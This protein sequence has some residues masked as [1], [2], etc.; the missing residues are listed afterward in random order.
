MKKKLKFSFILV[1]ILCLISIQNTDQ[2][3][4]PMKKP[5]SSSQ[6]DISISLH[7]E[8]FASFN[9]L[10]ENITSNDFTINHNGWTSDNMSIS[11][12]NITGKMAIKTIQDEK[13]SEYTKF[14]RTTTQDSPNKLYWMQQEYG[15]EIK[16]TKNV[17]IYASEMQFQFVSSSTD[18]N[19]AQ[20][21]IDTTHFE[22]RNDNGD[23]QPHKSNSL[24]SVPLNESWVINKNQSMEDYCDYPNTFTTLLIN[25]SYNY[26]LAKDT[27]YWIV[28]NATGESYT[29]PDYTNFGFWAYYNPDLELMTKNRSIDALP[30][31]DFSDGFVLTG[32]ST[33]WSENANYHPYLKLYYKITDTL[34]PEEIALNISSPIVSSIGASNFTTLHNLYQKDSTL[35]QIESNESIQYSPTANGSC[36]RDYDVSSSSTYKIHENYI[37]WTIDIPISALSE[38]FYE[39][40]RN[41]TLDLPSEFY[42]WEVVNSSTNNLPSTDHYIRV[43]ANSS[44]H[45][46]FIDV[47]EN[48]KRGDN[49]QIIINGFGTETA[50]VSIYNTT[51]DVIYSELKPFNTIFN[52]PIAESNGLG[53]FT[54]NVSYENGE[55]I[56]LKSRSFTVYDLES[57]DITIKDTNPFGN[58]NLPLTKVSVNNGSTT[59]IQTT[60][61]DGDALTFI[62]FKIGL[63]YYVNWSI[64]KTEY[65]QIISLIDKGQTDFILFSDDPYYFDTNIEVNVFQQDGTSPLACTILLNNTQI[66]APFGSANYIDYRESNYNVSVIYN[67]DIINST[68]FEIWNENTTINV[69]TEILDEY[70][71]TLTI[72]D[73]LYRNIN[74][75]NI[76]IANDTEIITTQSTNNDGVVGFGGLPIGEYNVSWSQ[77]NHVK[78][79]LLS[80][81]E[82]TVDTIISDEMWYFD[83][84]VT[85]TILDMTWDEN[86]EKHLGFICDVY[87]N[88]TELSTNNNGQITFPSIKEGKYNIAIKYLGE[89]VYNESY[90]IRK[91][92][93][94]SIEIITDIDAHES[95]HQSDFSLVL[96]DIYGRTLPNNVEIYVWNS[97]YNITYNLSEEG[98][99]SITNLNFGEYNVSWI[100]NGIVYNQSFWNPYEINNGQIELLYTVPWYF[101]VNVSL[102]IKDTTYDEYG[103]RYLGLESLVK[104]N[105][106]E[107]IT[108]EN[109]EVIFNSIIEGSYTISVFFHETLIYTNIFTIQKENSS[110]IEIITQYDNHKFLHQKEIKLQLVDSLNRSIPNTQIFL[111][112]ANFQYN[113][114]TDAQ[115][116]LFLSEIEIGN[117]NITWEQQ[118][119][120]YTYYNL[121]VPFDTEVHI[122]TSVS[123]YYHTITI[124][125]IIKDTTS[126]M[127][128]RGFVCNI[129]LNN[130]TKTSNDNGEV[131][132]DILE[133]NYTVSIFLHEKLIATRHIEILKDVNQSFIIITEIDAHPPIFKKDIPWWGW[134]VIASGLI[135][136]LTMVRRIKQKHKQEFIE[137]NLRQMWQEY[138]HLIED[139]Q[140]IRA[141]MVTHNDTGSLISK[142]ANNMKV[143]EKGDKSD[144]IS[145]FLDAISNWVQELDGSKPLEMIKWGD[146]YILI[147]RGSLISI[148]SI[149]T[150]PINS[151]EFLSRIKNTV[152]SIEKHYQDDLVSFH[153]NIKAFQTLH[154][155]IE[156]KLLLHHQYNIII[157]R[158]EIQKADTR[159][160]LYLQE[161]SNQP[162]FLLDLIDFIQTNL[163]ID[164]ELY[165]IIYLAIREE[166]IQFKK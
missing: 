109:G 74:G 11:F 46:S 84:D 133:G 92:N 63:D 61:V 153:G 104:M 111:I 20:K 90:T 118:Y 54:I 88:E 91:E 64:G 43:I 68:I 39:S 164:N 150:S 70:S 136:G 49:M 77:N 14:F 17:Y 97:T 79:K 32:W 121:S 106:T 142:W 56:G 29:Y 93:S 159:I 163:D 3:Q 119:D 19:N 7:E 127:E 65:S 66:N 62:D 45:V 55:K 75:L 112:N 76:I 131:N 116:F 47:N 137:T 103:E 100:Q 102:N 113:G 143:L 41:I 158:L 147:N 12:N 15:Q 166:I 4:I 36:Y 161:K 124:Q 51:H 141:I 105:E 53:I 152:A 140:N 21:V 27:S 8:F 151:K 125:L 122:I 42:E 108:N 98:I 1:M 139:E 24:I 33:D 22:L 23:D 67:D 144:L 9:S 83:I 126:E 72:K 82:N 10:Q 37:N 129:T 34:L 52:V 69:Y 31:G 86:G 18:S 30:N 132:F 162:I 155:D 135:V 134:I 154:L 145:G 146:F 87:L 6:I 110:S 26:N 59:Y 44:N 16:F 40:G 96:K 85:M 115:G 60:N 57:I 156:S 35:I 89:I 148:T 101:N 128:H 95:E 48:V 80:I 5:K 73:S 25:T 165:H 13:S 50:N 94:T 71:L 117:Y 114:T 130:I 149:S 81:E 160:R 58:R 107:L 2:H 99:V 138:R 78:W 28:F 123:L 38:S 157:N 120:L